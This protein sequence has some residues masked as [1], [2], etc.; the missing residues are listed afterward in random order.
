MKQEFIIMDASIKYMNAQ[1]PLDEGL[2]YTGEGWARGLNRAFK[3][4]AASFA[5]EKAKTLKEEA[6]V[7]VFMLQ[8]NGPNINFAEV[9]F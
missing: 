8:I 2:M 4:E 6:P 7:R 1:N 3:Y 5:I 9:K